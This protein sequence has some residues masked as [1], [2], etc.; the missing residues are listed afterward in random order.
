MRIVI[1]MQGAQTASRVRGIGRVTRNL[2]EAIIRH[3]GHEVHLALNALLPDAIDS[4]H[5]HFSQLIPKEHIHFWQAVPPLAAIEGISSFQ[6]R[7][8]TTI[9]SEF[10]ASLYPD[11]VLVPSMCEGTGDDFFCDFLPLKGKCLLASVV[12]DFIPL[13]RRNECLPPELEPWYADRLAQLSLMDLLFP[14][15]SF[16]S[17]E[18]GKYLP[19]IP[20]QILLWGADAIFCPSHI[21]DQR[22]RD[23]YDAHGISRAFVLYTGGLDERKNVKGLLKAYQLLPKALRKCFQLVIPCGG[24]PYLIEEYS[25]QLYSLGLSQE[26][27]CLLGFISETDI[28]DLYSLCSLFVFPSLDEGF[29]LPVLEAAK[30]GA[31]IICS[32]ATAVPEILDC[33][34]ALFDPEDVSSISQKMEQALTD[35]EFRLK[36]ARRGEERAALFSWENCAK[37]ALAALEDM[38]AGRVASWPK[39]DKGRRLA[40]ICKRLSQLQT[41]KHDSVKLANALARTFPA[42]RAPQVLVDI[43]ILAKL[44][45][46]TGIQRAVRS[47]CMEMIRQPLAGRIVRFIRLIEQRGY[48]VYAH[49]AALRLF[50]YDDGL[51][52][53]VPVDYGHDDVFLGLDIVMQAIL[54]G[55]NCLK[56]MYWNGVRIYF[57]VHDLIPILYPAY[58]TDSIVSCFPYWLKG[59]C[60]FNGLVCVSKTTAE[61]VRQWLTKEGLVR[62]NLKISTFRLGAEIDKNNSTTDLSADAV[63]TL[64]CMRVRPTFLMV[65][66]L[67][68]SKGHRQ[69]LAAMEQLWDK[70]IDANLV[71]VGKSGWKM[72]DFETKLKLHSEQG[73]HLFW[74]CSISDEYLAKVYE[75]ATA[76]LMAS[77]AEGFGLP[78]IEA[79]QYGKPLILRDIPVFREIAGDNAFYFVGLEPQDLADV[80]QQW[81]KAYAHK[82]IPSSTGIRRV[83]WRESCQS[84]IAALDL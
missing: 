60:K 44:D 25:R 5:N 65:G 23:L 33:P 12:H 19:G 57:V 53:D 8:A 56:T 42:D 21:S 35:N 51:E 77:E 55:E 52:H 26:D 2:A 74:L 82:D 1:D 76:V 38:A 13:R 81:L 39:E 40:H 62:P 14:I 41:A 54:N 37:T 75:A 34:E 30:C 15:S 20:T 46:G 79:A 78:I 66:T 24:Q 7:Q 49:E 69:T 72:D 29:G 50:C 63:E 59:V 32:K 11:A 43:S 9:Y 80:L 45:G 73:K 17:N 16:V 47:I 67:E 28:R 6:R 4:L 22:R 10:L 61:S 36:L 27:V 48:Y 83:S 3:G 31:P 64:S 84:L 70:G 18:C 58:V 71:I 68:P